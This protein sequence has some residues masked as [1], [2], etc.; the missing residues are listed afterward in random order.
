HPELVRGDGCPDTEFMRHVPG[1]ASK[2]GAEGLQGLGLADQGLGVA[3]R[4]EDGNGRAVAP[5]VVAVLGALLGWSEPPPG[6]VDFVAP[7]L[8]NS[9]GDRV[10]R[11]HASVRLHTSAGASL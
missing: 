5:V 11:L 6:L 9:P 2:S 3:V 8:R 7:E 1:C 4:V 10:G